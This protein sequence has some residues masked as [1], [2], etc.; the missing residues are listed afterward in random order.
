MD[1]TGMQIQPQTQNRNQTGRSLQFSRTEYLCWAT[2]LWAKVHWFHNSWP[3]SI[4]TLMIRVSVSHIVNHT[5]THTFSSSFP[6]HIKVGHIAMCFCH[7]LTLSQTAV[8]MRTQTRQIN[9]YART[10]KTIV[11]RKSIVSVT[12]FLSF[13][14]PPQ[15]TSTTLSNINNNN[16]NKPKIYLYFDFVFIQLQL[17]E[18]QVQ[19][20]IE[21]DSN[22]TD[23]K[24]L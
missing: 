16:K 4:Y 24:H 5:R 6:S 21:R 15:Q 23:G 19:I 12:I 7:T 22:D 20:K 17:G 18:C 14:L 1:H 13:L 9:H 2:Y 10:E 8:R 3:L 11:N